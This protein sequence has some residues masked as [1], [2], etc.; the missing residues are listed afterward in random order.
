MNTE[1]S[2]STCK[3]LNDVVMVKNL[4]YSALIK[5]KLQPLHVNT[6]FLTDFALASSTD[7]LKYSINYAVV[8][9]DFKN[10]EKEHKEQNYNSVVSLAKH[11]IKDVAFK[12]NCQ[13]VSVELELKEENFEVSLT[14][15]RTISD[16]KNIS[17]VGNDCVTIKN[18]S[19]STIIGIFT[20]ERFQKQPVVLNIDLEINLDENDSDFSIVGS[21]ISNYVENSNF[22]T[23]E[24]LVLNVNKMIYKLIPFVNSCNVGVLKTDII[25]YS[26][27]GVSSKR[28]KKEISELDSEIV[29]F[30][31]ENVTTDRFVI[32][33]LN[34]ET[35]T[36]QIDT[37]DHIAFIAF[38]SNIGH[39]LHN[40][41][42]AIEELNLHD[43]IEV[44]Q[45][46]SLYK[47]KPMYY[48]DQ[49]DFIN[50]CLKIKTTLTPH[51]LLKVLKDI[52]Y[53]SLKR[54][55]HFDNCPRTIDLDIILYDSLIVNTSDLNIPHIRMIERTFVLVPLCE[56]IPP[57]F[58]HPVTAEPVHDHLKQLMESEPKTDL[59]ESIDLISLVP[60]PTRFPMLDE[61]KNKSLKFRYLEYDLVHSKTATQL[62]AI[63]N[64]TPDSFS[65]GCEANLDLES[66][67]KKVDEMYE[68]NVD[69][70]DVGGCSTRPGSL[71]PLI[72]D[73]MNRVIPVVKEIK[74]KYAESVIIS[75]DTY[76]SEVAEEAIKAGADII[77]DISAGTFDDKM[78]DVIAKYNV[79]YVI[80][81][82]RGDIKTM[83][84]L[85]D[86]GQ[87]DDG[88]LKI[89]NKR[90][91]KEDI[92]VTEIAKELSSN[93]EKMYAKGVKRWQI[94]LDPGL[95]FAKNLSQNLSVI[96][97]LPFFKQYKQFDV[98]T[99]TYISFD[100]M[101]VL[102]G[103]SRKKFIGTITGK[104]TAAERING[105]SASITAGIG[106]GS[107]IVRVHDFKEMK[108]VCLM[109]D[110]IYKNIH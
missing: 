53:L 46:S 6:K 72:D 11:L 23:V 109:G 103:P 33:N 3:I 68:N 50:G 32:P 58:I 65:D 56:L 101:P 69:I 89:Y 49:P 88:D 42:Q 80:N 5:N 27:V 107:D 30:A 25:E 70:I 104:E 96:R 62:M 28:N 38:G 95:G 78:Y 15:N 16:D 24:A 76:R 12:Q 7:D 35:Q 87:T 2:Q 31:D 91:T 14:L 105:T 13:N 51:E 10:Y 90:I 77:N 17:I 79:P 110:A 1:H 45:T 83:A 106:F 74:K 18:L 100:Y 26:D 67:M 37:G 71:Q 36:K 22:K 84:K 73:E 94:I 47:S 102:L 29:E 48:L 39:Q 54:I 61:D 9:R 34:Q 93:I 64:I 86:Y 57:D 20:F 60:L 41:L 85:V 99:K 19:V 40:I 59:Q 82:T 97:D 44:L 43:K 75:V 92:I 8:C 63:L 52:E 4:E 21:T 55:K 81:H 98:K 66:T 108:D